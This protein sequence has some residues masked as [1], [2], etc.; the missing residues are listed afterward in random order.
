MSK[1]KT[2]LVTGASGFIGRESVKALSKAGWRVTCGGRSI[3]SSH[4]C[5]FI[6]LDLSR[7]AEIFALADSVRFDAIVHLGAHVSWARAADVDMYL[8]N[9]ISSGSL[10][11]LASN[12]GAHLIFSSS[13]AVCGIRK[14]QIAQDSLVAPDTGYA[15]TK[16]LAEQLIVVGCAR[17]CILRIG[18]VFGLN[19]P[20]HLGLNRA[21]AD[22]LRGVPPTLVGTG[23]ALR[24]YI[25]VKDVA[26]AIVYALENK[27]IGTHLL[28]GSDVLS[29]GDML[30]KVC[31]AFMPDQTP[32]RNDGDEAFDQVVFTSPSF[33][34]SRSFMEALG[35]I[36]NSNQ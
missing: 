15:Q 29:I 11:Y 31:K 28:S 18:G 30:D 16:W 25:Y 17:H 26:S 8:P 19:G 6:K 20:Q 23:R 2:V 35:D 10:A 22:A 14:N 34:K 24:N 7:P 36:R 27:I 9:V 3:P 21:I 1:T 12:W 4:E 32:V 5:E 33:P 13:I